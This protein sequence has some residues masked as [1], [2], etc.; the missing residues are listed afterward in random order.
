MAS[1][2]LAVI[3]QGWLELDSFNL[4][5]VLN[6]LDD[7]DNRAISDAILFQMDNNC[8]F[9]AEFGKLLDDEVDEIRISLQFG[10]VF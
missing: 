5:G 10:R 6:H 9:G 8:I 7:S 4:R 2:I 1:S 3:P